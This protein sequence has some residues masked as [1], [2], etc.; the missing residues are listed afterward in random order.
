[1]PDEDIELV[2][3]TIYERPRD[4]P[5]SYVLRGH[6]IER[7]GTRPHDVCFVAATLEE[8]RTQLPLGVHCLPRSP[9][10]EPQ[11]VESWI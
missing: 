9:D 8:V 1:M 2:I 11:I 5:D 7:G 6:V 4:F 3:W 10:D